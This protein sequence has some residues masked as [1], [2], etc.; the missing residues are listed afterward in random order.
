[1]LEYLAQDAETKDYCYEKEEMRKE[2]RDE[3]I[4]C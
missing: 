1:M 3:E 2:Q 4:Q